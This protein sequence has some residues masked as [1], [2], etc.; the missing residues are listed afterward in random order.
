MPPRQRIVARY[1]TRNLGRHNQSDIALTKFRKTNDTV[2]A[3]RFVG[4]ALLA[5]PDLCYRPGKVAVPFHCIHAEI[6]MCIDSKHGS[7][8]FNVDS[9]MSCNILDRTRKRILSS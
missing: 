7:I 3:I 8:E 1:I 4:Q 6:E 9:K 2:S 5:I